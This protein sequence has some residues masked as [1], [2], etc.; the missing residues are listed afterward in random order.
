MAFKPILFSTPM[1]EALLNGRKTQTR[2]V[3]KPLTPEAITKLMYLDLGIEVQKYKA[4][5]IRVDS[6][7]RIGDLL[8][9]RETWSKDPQN[10]GNYRF[11]EDWKDIGIYW[12][13]KPSIHMPFNAARIF[14]K[15]KDIRIEKLHDITAADAKSEG[16]KLDEDGHPINYFFPAGRVCAQVSFETLWMKING[17]ESWEDNPWVWVYV[18][19]VLKT[20]PGT[21]ISCGCTDD[22]CLGC[23]EK[24]GSPCSW[25]NSNHTVCSACRPSKIKS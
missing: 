17:R 24:T 4:E 3:I 21:C 9:V 2:R 1:V 20:N 14:L 18:L 19:E 7:Y 11:K 15:V 16:I 22:N 25:T 23:I 6:K 10:L 5:L 12:K 13:W 8:W